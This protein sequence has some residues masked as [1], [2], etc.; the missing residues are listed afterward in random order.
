MTEKTVSIEVRGAI[1]IVTLNRPESANTLNMQMGRD[2]AAAAIACEGNAAVRAVVLT[3]AGKH[4][5]FGG[6]LRGMVAGGE[7]IEPYLRELTS[8]L[9]TAISHFVRM[10]APVVAA[11]NG[12]AAGAGVG[13]VAMSDIAL[14]GDGAKFSLAYTGV[15][16]TPD[17]STSFYLPR[18]V[19]LKRAVELILTNR[20][21]TA[22]EA[23]QWGLVNAVV[24]EAEVV[25]RAIE[26]AERL[27][28]G[29]THAF[30]ESKR[31]LAQSMGA[32]ESHMALESQTIARQAASA[33]GREGI[34]AFL[35]KRKP[36]YG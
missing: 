8:H 31:L 34:G 25:T 6:D 27:A 35:E 11:V 32:L 5:C 9:H 36:K 22:T 19:G 4:F 30:G 3:G 15:G 26:M 24:P 29:P 12:T 14:A 17:G 16:L 10:D 20:V 28:A 13:L 21:L 1:A 7:A 18:V 23:E 2:L 33:E